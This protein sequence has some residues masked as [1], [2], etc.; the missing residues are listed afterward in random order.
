MYLQRISIGSDLLLVNAYFNLLLADALPTY[1]I[2]NGSSGCTYPAVR[3][4]GE[5]VK[6]VRPSNACPS[7]S[8]GCSF[9]SRGAWEVL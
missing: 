9:Q 6:P 2:V 1:T 3:M 7:L 4:T 8:P 5:R